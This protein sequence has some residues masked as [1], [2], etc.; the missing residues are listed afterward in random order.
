MLSAED[1]GY[2]NLKIINQIKRT[3]RFRS[4][5]FPIQVFTSEPAERF[6]HSALDNHCSCELKKREAVLCWRGGGRDMKEFFTAKCSDCT[7]GR[8]NNSTLKEQYFPKR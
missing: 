5:Q 1:I 2:I 7:P 8:F 6:S 4:Y 3:H